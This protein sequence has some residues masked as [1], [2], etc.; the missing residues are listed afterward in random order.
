MFIYISA[1]H[2]L[3][4]ERLDDHEK[5]DDAINHVCEYDYSFYPENDADRRKEIE[6]DLIEKYNPILRW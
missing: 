1:K 5:W 6:H 2:I 3:L 4:I